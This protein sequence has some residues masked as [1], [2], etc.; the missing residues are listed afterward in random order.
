MLIG[1]EDAL[2]IETILLN[3]VS[4]RTKLDNI[5]F[6]PRN[7]VSINLTLGSVQSMRFLRLMSQSNSTENHS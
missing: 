3:L 7:V 4:N 1:H 2:G 5:S 6:D